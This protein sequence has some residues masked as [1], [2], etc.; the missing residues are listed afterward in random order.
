MDEHARSFPGFIVD[1]DS[2]D[3]YASYLDEATTIVLD[4]ETKPFETADDGQYPEVIGIAAYIV[5]A[6]EGGFSEIGMYFP[7]GHDPHPMF[8]EAVQNGRNNLDEAKF[9]VLRLIL[10]KPNKILIGHNLPF[11]FTCL[12]KMGWKLPVNIWYDTLYG[13]HLV[14]EEL[15]SFQ[16]EWLASV[17]LGDKNAGKFTS[18]LHKLSK[19]VGGLHRL[20]IGTVGQYS[21]GD[22]KRTYRLYKQRVSPQFE[23]QELSKVWWPYEAQFCLELAQITKRGIAIDP[24]KAKELAEECQTQMRLIRDSLGFDPAKP[25][26]LAPRLFAPEPKGLGLPIGKLSTR[27]QNPP[28]IS[29][30]G[31]KIT[32]VP[33]MDAPFLERY[34]GEYPLIETVLQ[35]RSY[36]K[37]YATWFQGWLDKRARDGRVHPSFKRHGTVTSRLS[38]SDPN[39]HQLPRR[40][41]SVEKEAKFIKHRVKSMLR[42]TPGHALVSFDYS[43]IEYRL[44]ACYGQ[45]EH[46]LDQLN[47]GADFHNITAEL[48]GIIRY[49]AKTLNFAILYGAGAA[50]IGS[51]LGTSEEE[52]KRLIGNIHDNMPGLFK[53]M[54]H[55]QWLALNTGEISLWTGRK[56][57]F[58]NPVR[59]AHKAFN[60]QIQGGAAEITRFSTLKL[61]RHHPDKPIV[62]TVHDD[63]WLEIPLENLDVAI[64]EV[65]ETME[66]PKE[67]FPVIF[68]VDYKILWHPDPQ[69][70]TS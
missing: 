12:K 16:L 43:Q 34:A 56:R 44:A 23:T 20:P 64:K 4:T 61:N 57:H 21:I 14:D 52:A 39:V 17:L 68:P 30:R 1:N 24:D 42:A 70:V 59:D 37:A 54:L 31:N 19:Q 51:M 53:Y 8:V 48:L 15:Q 41:D 69:K 35:Y 28:F 3:R 26:Q 36:Q 29:I 67:R 55:I 45:D 46:V 22:V 63:L 27:N 13:M 10:E 62:N 47:N 38:S 25:A 66:W 40:S 18:A 9:Q 6:T 5:R 65:Q 49:A 7:F 60:S 58:G 32:K 2:F 11:D 50:K 33:V